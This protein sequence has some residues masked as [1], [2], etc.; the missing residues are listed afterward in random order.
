M[1]VELIFYV[2]IVGAVVAALAYFGDRLEREPL[3]RIFNAIILGI[4]ATLIVVILKRALP[5][6]LFS[7]SPNLGNTILVNFLSVGL[8]EETAK[9]FV[10]LFFIYK[11]D[12]FNEYYD[13][14]LY[15]GL[16][17]IGFAMS[18]N[19]SYMVK[20]LAH[21][22]SSGINLDEGLARFIALHVLIKF[23][24]YPGHF[25]FGFISGYFVSGGK[26]RKD[27]GK[28]NE[29][30]YVGIG[31]VLA[32]L[33]HGVHNTIALRG[34]LT[35]FQGYILFLLLIALFVGWKSKKRSV[36]RKD[37]LGKLSEK[38]RNTLK[39][40]LLASKKEKITLGYVMMLCILILVCQF[41]VY[42]LMTAIL[43]F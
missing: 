5:L 34:S 27:D 35:L 43:S 11:W 25:L 39:E 8:V 40:I 24:L 28:I 12:D 19:L 7:T 10:I 22:L 9:F 36:F 6:P 14:P 31:F 38:K 41:I 16:V 17:G 3:F 2:F 29:V 20:P 30:L 4:A 13:G 42:F 37:V 15:A 18:E 26:F 21:A 32:T 33:M 23:R 1:I